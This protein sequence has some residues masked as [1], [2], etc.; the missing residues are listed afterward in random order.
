MFLV[1]G[2]IAERITGKSWEENIQ[3]QF[4]KP[5]KMTRSNLSIDDMQ[6]SSNAAFGYKLKND[7]IISK[8][9]YYRIAAMSPAGSINSSVNEMS[10]W[11]IT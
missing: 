7:S 1:Q 5:L 4:F 2:V 9:D 6:K 8:T 10:N 3:E 11:I